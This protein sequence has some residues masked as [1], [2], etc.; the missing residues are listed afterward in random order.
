MHNQRVQSGAS[1]NAACGWLFHVVLNIVT[2]LWILV[3]ENKVN[4]QKER[5]HLHLSLGFLIAHLVG[6]SAL[7]RAKHN[8]VWRLVVEALW[9]KLIFGLCEELQVST[10]AI[11][12]VLG[13]HFVSVSQSQSRYSGGR[14]G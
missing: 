3:S 12:V 14:P 7:I 1:S 9:G 11:Q 8:C 6:T 10:T 2:R 4:L 5:L 13:L